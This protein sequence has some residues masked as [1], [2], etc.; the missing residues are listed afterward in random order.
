MEM[1]NTVHNATLRNN[2]FQGNGYSI[3]ETQV[4][5]TGHDWNYDNWNT[6]SGNYH[7]KWENVNYSTIA[8][9]CK[10]TGLECNGHEEA[11]G[12]ANPGGGNFS[13]LPTSPNI[14]RGIAIPG[15]NDNFSGSAPDIGAFESVFGE[16]TATP[17]ATPIPTGT[18]TLQ[19]VVPSVVSILRLDPSPTSAN[20]VRFSI[21]FS[22]EVS[23]VDTGDFTFFTTGTVANA[24]IAEVNGAGKTYT[25]IVNTGTGDGTLRLDLLDND[26]ILDSD[27]NP[28]GGPGAANGNFT[29]GEIYN[30]NRSAPFLISSLRADPSPTSAGTVRYTLA[31]SEPVSGVDVADFSLPASG[32]VGAS[33]ANVSGA[34]SAYIVTVN[35]GS[36]SGFFRLDPH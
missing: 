21:N 32:V 6:T 34:D 29:S 24:A 28:L 22:K 20:V 17:S 30:I 2:I 31:F 19:P 4:G 11:P 35:T 18:P 3:E 8:Q 25:V 1:I 5:S 12:L 36:G 9:L 14:N 7:F 26:S 13:L 33:V 27:S 15:I 16:P 10:A 23:G